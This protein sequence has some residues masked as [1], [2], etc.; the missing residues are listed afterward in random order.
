MAQRG[1]GANWR[2]DF[3]VTGV[4]FY[5]S[6][7]GKAGAGLWYASKVLARRPRNEW[8]E[9]IKAVTDLPHSCQTLIILC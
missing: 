3:G 9:G 5:Q 1:I 8:P 2:Q 7:G 6:L 4:W